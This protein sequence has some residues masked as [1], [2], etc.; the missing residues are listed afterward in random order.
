MEK[1]GGANAH[2]K[3]FPPH[4]LP[5]L[6]SINQP[7][8]CSSEGRRPLSSFLRVSLHRGKEVRCQKSETGPEEEKA[9]THFPYCAL[10]LSKADGATLHFPA[11]HE[12]EGRRFFFLLHAHNFPCWF[13]LLL[14]FFLFFPSFLPPRLFM[15]MRRRR[16]K[17]S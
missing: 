8:H 3:L 7:P 5:F 17:S 4:R 10:L 9:T 15:V 6:P 13:L 12:E 14:L 16:R 1:R 11:K 2:N